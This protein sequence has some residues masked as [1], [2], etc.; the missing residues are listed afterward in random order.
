MQLCQGKYLHFQK[1]SP[2]PEPSPERP[3]F[4]FDREGL[5]FAYRTTRPEWLPGLAC[6]FEKALHVLV[7]A[8]LGNPKA[9]AVH[10]AGARGKHIACIIGHHRQSQKVG[11]RYRLSPSTQ[12]FVLLLMCFV[13][14]NPY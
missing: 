4:L 10:P 3:A 13:G 5:A 7:G 12:Y 1:F 14:P 11:S 6:E 9:A 2:D 8:E